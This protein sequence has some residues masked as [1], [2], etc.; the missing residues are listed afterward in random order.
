MSTRPATVKED[1]LIMSFHE[2]GHL[3]ATII[4]EYFGLR[5]PAV[6]INLHGEFRAL[7]GAKKLRDT[8]EPRAALEST[9]EFVRIALA[10]KAAEDLL[11]QAHTTSGQRIIPGQGGAAH[12][13]EQARA[14][15]AAQDMEDEMPALSEETRKLIREQWEMV[16]EI[17]DVI[18]RAT[19]SAVSKEQINSLPS[20]RKFESL[21]QRP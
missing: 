3:A 15:L 20:V 11:S 21:H 5:D 2:A 19:T 4:S 10:G 16:T 12:D 14:T 6:E 17:A 7:A 13:V 8:R 18:F 9:R 1:R